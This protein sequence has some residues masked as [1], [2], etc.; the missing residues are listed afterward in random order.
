MTHCYW[1]NQAMNDDARFL[2]SGYVILQNMRMWSAENPHYFEETPL[3]PQ[4]IGIRCAISRRR[5]F[6]RFSTRSLL[7]LRDIRKSFRN[8]L[9]S[10]ILKN[11][12]MDIFSMTPQQLIQLKQVW[13][14]YGSFQSINF[15]HMSWLIALDY[16]LFPILKNTIFNKSVDTI[17]RLRTYLIYRPERSQANIDSKRFI[18]KPTF[19]IADLICIH[20]EELTHFDHLVGLYNE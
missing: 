5:Q 7:Q 14:F 4:K 13:T 19:V 8:L 15:N 11:C 9:T 2:L 12:R 20:Y 6:K 16:F 3:H 10:L 1:F 18:Y 17:R